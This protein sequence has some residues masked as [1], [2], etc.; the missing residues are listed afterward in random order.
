[1]QLDLVIDLLSLRPKENY[2]LQPSDHKLYYYKKIILLENK[3][4]MII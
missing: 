3:R 1:M 4:L 2:Y